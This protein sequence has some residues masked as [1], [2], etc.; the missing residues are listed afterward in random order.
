[1][2]N[3]LKAK[4]VVLW[5]GEGRKVFH[6][7]WQAA[8]GALVAG[9]LAAKSTNDVKATVMVAVATGLAAVKALVVSRS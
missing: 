4:L 6:T 3:F 1:M 8:I 5:N 9:L 7:F 2:Y